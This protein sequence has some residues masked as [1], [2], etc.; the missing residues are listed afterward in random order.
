MG[1]QCATIKHPA[2]GISFKLCASCQD[3]Y[4]D[5]RRYL[6]DG[7]MDDLPYWYNKEW[8]RQWL[9]WLDYQ[10]ALNHYMGSQEVLA[11]LQE[12]HED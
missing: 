11:I 7:R 10:L 2:H 1:D 12:L 9:A 4:Q 3:E 6:E 8:V 5:L